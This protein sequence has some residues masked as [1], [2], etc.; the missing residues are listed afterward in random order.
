MK[1]INK[2]P[3]TWVYL[4]HPLGYDP[5]DSYGTSYMVDTDQHELLK[6]K[7]EIVDAY[8]Q[9]ASID[10][11]IASAGVYTETKTAAFNGNPLL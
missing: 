4:T 11:K 1:R 5:Y 8:L 2:R 3:R 6:I 9:H 10:T 7:S